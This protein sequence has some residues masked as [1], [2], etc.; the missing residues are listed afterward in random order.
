MKKE[1]ETTGNR[2][3]YFTTD[4]LKSGLKKRAVKGAG[5]AV[6]S[7]ISTFVIQMVST[8]ILARI[9]TPDDFGLVAMVTSISMLFKMFRTMGLTQATVQAEIITHKQISTL[10]WINIG[11]CVLITLA[12]M[13]LSPVIAAFYKEPQLK[14]IAIVLS[15][16]IILGGGATQHLALLKRNMQFVKITLT[17]II[18]SIISVIVA[19]VFAM[20]GFGYWALVAR[21]LALGVSIT[22]GAWLC[23]RW[24]PSLPSYGTGVKPMLKFGLHSIGAFTVDYFSRNLDKLLIGWKFGPQALGFYDKAFQLFAAPSQQLTVPLTSVAVSTLSRLRD[25]PERYNRYYLKAVSILGFLGMLVSLILTIIG[26]D[27]ILFLLGPQWGKAGQLFSVFGLGIGIMLVSGTHR[28]LHLSQGNAD[29]LFSWGIINSLLT[30]MFLIVGLFFGILEVAVFYTL[31]LYVLVGPALW[32]ACKPISLNVAS[33]FLTTW[34]FFFSALL[35]GV[36]C[37]YLIHTFPLTSQTISDLHILTRITLNASMS[38][39][40]YTLFIIIFFRGI[41]PLLDIISL[42]KDF[43]PRR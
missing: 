33:I 35:A 5:V 25:E 9:L 31:S 30:I 32:Y 29:R 40:F 15:L 6:F 8:V 43:F 13:C 22:I 18:S 17:E 10:F 11:F 3:D 36:A 26:Q 38:I 1:K 39:F 42:C 2:H 12:L 20:N 37:S 7:Q 27:F 14:A 4:H 41:K 24:T 19:I 28:W 16:D 21:R 34:K 23:C